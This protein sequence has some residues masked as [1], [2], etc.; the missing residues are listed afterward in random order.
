MKPF[1]RICAFAAL[2]LATAHA[3]EGKWESI[4]NG[5]DMEGRTPKIRGLAMGE[6]A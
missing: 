6:A 4:F 5:K 1:L 2:V 3:E